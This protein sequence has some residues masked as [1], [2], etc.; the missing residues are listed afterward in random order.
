[1]NIGFAISVMVS[2]L[3]VLMILISH[4]FLTTPYDKV[5]SGDDE[6]YCYIGN[7]YKHISKE[8]VIGFD[9]EHGVWIFNNGHAK[10]CTVIVRKKLD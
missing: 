5:K 8:S 4:F 3:G 9:D 6:L 1:M 10:N 2:F 7:T